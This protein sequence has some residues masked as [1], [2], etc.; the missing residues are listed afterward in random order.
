MAN[1]AHD[2]PAKHP[3]IIVRLKRPPTKKSKVGFAADAFYRLCVLHSICSYLEL[4]SMSGAWSCA[5]SCCVLDALLC[6]NCIKCRIAAGRDG[7]CILGNCLYS[8]L[9]ASCPTFY[10]VHDSAFTLCAGCQA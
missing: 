7:A 6:L 5:A 1:E 2:G 8:T 10:P 4:I 3:K 9:V